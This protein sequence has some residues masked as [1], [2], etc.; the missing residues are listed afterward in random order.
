MIARHI[1]LGAMLALSALGFTKSAWATPDA[2]PAIEVWK[3]PSCGCCQKWADYLTANGF[4]V[5]AKNTT[6]G[7][8]DRIKQQAG[9]SK[10]ISSCH[11]A[12]VDGYAIEGHVPAE[13]IKRL[14]EERPDAA[15]LS[16]PD[17]PLGSPGMEVPDG[18]KEPFDVLLVK[19]DGSTEVFAKH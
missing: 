19:K 8:L 13:D 4:D 1:V 14:L 7:M 11:T 9:I 5:A 3:S 16:V 12:L 6:Y 18:T 17:M 2:R 15:G 10:D